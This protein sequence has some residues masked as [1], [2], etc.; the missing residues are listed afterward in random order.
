MKAE[1]NMVSP[2]R[3]AYVEEEIQKR[4]LLNAL[5]HGSSKHIWKTFHFL[6][7]RELNEIN[8]KLMPLYNFF[9]AG[10]SM[11]NWLAEEDE[12][13]SDPK[14]L[15]G[16]LAGINQVDF[17]QGEHAVLKSEAICFPLLICELNKSVFDYLIC[18]G[19]P[20]DLS[21]D[22]LI[23]YYAKSDRYDHEIW[24]YLLGPALWEKM[25]QTI[26]VQP[27]QLPRIISELSKL[28]LKQLTEIFTLI[29]DEKK[30]EAQEILKQLEIL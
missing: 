20:S 27:D 9:T 7:E 16:K 29:I 8:P 6:A 12:I 28:N 4:I 3:L 22:E 23:Y 15:Q 18:T 5:V 21:D 14:E 24:H 2:D 13:S 17:Q 1:T 11:L 26:K 30:T 25:L 19:I 10:I